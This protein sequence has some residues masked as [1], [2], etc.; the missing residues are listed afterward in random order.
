MAKTN[1]IVKGSSL[2]S[3]IRIATENLLLAKAEGETAESSLEKDRKKLLAENKRLT[4][5]RGVLTRKKQIAANRLKKTPNAE[6]RKAA[7]SII[8]E[9]TVIKKAADKARAAKNA[10]TEELNSVK[11]A[12]KQASAYISMMEKAD[13]VLNKPRKKVRKKR[14]AAV[15]A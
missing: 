6:N 4:K 12:L 13:K 7:S 9:L 1:K 3:K 10:S 8:K 5:K 11:T 15:A 14:R 2:A